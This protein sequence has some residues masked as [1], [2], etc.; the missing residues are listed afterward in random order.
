MYLLFQY[1]EVR[2]YRSTVV[3]CKAIKTYFRLYSMLLRDNSRTFYRVVVIEGVI[4][5]MLV[6]VEVTV[7]VVV[8]SLVMLPRVLVT[9]IIMVVVW[10]VWLW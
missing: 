9:V 2:Y 1:T 3:I 8:M 4:I 7:V 6:V 10:L 5:V